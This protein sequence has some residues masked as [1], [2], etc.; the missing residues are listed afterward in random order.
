MRLCTMRCAFRVG[1]GMQT[2]VWG[3]KGS[4][5][6]FYK[7]LGLFGVQDSHGGRKVANGAVF[8]TLVILQVGSS[9]GFDL[10]WLS[11]C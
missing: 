1:G 4:G 11:A 10:G 3:L 6:G 2:E 7:D 8:L 5:F 9:P